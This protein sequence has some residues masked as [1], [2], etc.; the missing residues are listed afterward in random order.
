MSVGQFGFNNGGGSI[1]AN[2][3]TGDLGGDNYRAR[4]RKRPVQNIVKNT[5]VNGYPYLLPNGNP[6][7]VGE[8]VDATGITEEVSLAPL[9]DGSQAQVSVQGAQGLLQVD[10]DGY[11]YYDSKQNYAVLEKTE[12][13]Y[14]NRFKVYD[15]PR[16]I[17]D[18]YIAG[19]IKD[20][21]YNLQGQFFPFD[22]VI[23]ETKTGE[24]KS[25]FKEKDG[26]L[27]NKYEK[28][29]RTYHFGAH[30][31]T[32]FIHENGGYTDAQ[33]TKPVTYEFSGDDDVWV[34][35]DGVL[36]GD[37]GGIHDA[38]SLEINFA[39]GEVVVFSKGANGNREEEIET[40]LKECYEAA[41]KE[42]E[43]SVNEKG[44]T[45]ADDSYHT[46][47]FFYLERGTGASNMQLKY[48]LLEIPGSS[49]IKQDQIGQAV[50]GAEFELRSNKDGKDILL[51]E[52]TTDQNGT[53][54]LMDARP[55]HN[56]KNLSLKQL[57]EEGF[58]NLTLKETKIPDGYRGQAEVQLEL[59]LNNE[60][61]G[62]ILVNQDPWKTGI[63][64]SPKVRTEIPSEAY[65]YTAG[66]EH[67][68]KVTLEQ[69]KSG[70]VFAVLQK[71]VDKDKPY[72]DPDAWIPIYGDREH[73]WH[74]LDSTGDAL[75]AVIQAFKKQVNEG[76]QKQIFK[77]SSN[78]VMALEID[79][80]PGDIRNYYSLLLDKEKDKT[81]YAIAYY[82]SE[83]P[84]VDGVNSEN[85]WRLD[86][87]ASL[88]IDGNKDFDRIFATNILVPNIKNTLYVQKTDESGKPLIGAQFSLYE[89][90]QVSEEN[91]EIKLNEN[92]QPYDT[93]T[94]QEHGPMENTGSFPSTNHLLKEGTYYL[95]E[96]RAPDGYIRNSN[97]TKII[98]NKEGVFAN[99]G[100]ADDGIVVARGVGGILKSMY[101]FATLDH[102]DNTLNNIKANMEI[103]DSN[104][105]E[106]L[107][108]SDPSKWKQGGNPTEMHLEYQAS[109][110]TLKYGAI[111]TTDNPNAENRI[112]TDTGWS[113]LNIQ[114]CK[115]HH[116]ITRSKG[117]SI[118]DLEGKNITNLFSNTVTVIVENERTNP[119]SIE[120]VV[121]D[122]KQMTPL[123]D[124]EFDVHLTYGKDENSQTPVTGDYPI[125]ITTKQNDDPNPVKTDISVL[126][127]DSS[128]NAK[129]QL[130]AGK[131]EQGQNVSQKVE[132]IN[133]PMGIHY[134]I[135]ETSSERF[136]TK[137]KTD[138]QDEMA[139]QQIT[140]A[141]AKTKGEAQANQFS[142]NEIT[143]TNVYSYL[144]FI[145]VN[146]A[147]Q[148]LQGVQFGLYELNCQEQS[149]N[150]QQL[151]NVDPSS[152]ELKDE[153]CWTKVNTFTSGEDGKVLLS[154]LI[155]GKQYRLV[156]LK[157]ANGYLLP[158]GQW[159]IKQNDQGQF[160]F[161]ESIGNPPAASNQGGQYYV[162][163]YQPNELPL[164]GGRGNTFFM[165]C[166]TALMSLG[167]VM[168][169]I[170]HKKRNVK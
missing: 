87:D 46:L 165:I 96:D 70:T 34:F 23:Y 79:D 150:H 161:G 106:D 131:N 12:N 22:P 84:T 155:E 128:G 167:L 33:K 25:I 8:G 130:Q 168:W 50:P 134:S 35:I 86:S 53:F 44:T 49:I 93:I 147:N 19:N 103:N 45:F 163:N 104:N 18:P 57:Y 82:Y 67:G 69:Q 76:Y 40:T 58:R 81:E 166:G 64:A 120:K 110:E 88:Q 109:D 111:K 63:Y 142:N 90:D 11:F 62:V 92:A 158:Q 122:P 89:S 24:T 80:L 139:S 107:D 10:Q 30:M 74:R 91:G 42:V 41:G 153:S 95:F 160:S 148:P 66:S 36:V 126:K 132:I 52:G 154:G 7:L 55:D 129:I 17:Y 146:K 121:Q 83:S 99:A 47:D 6:N 113:R 125:K 3:W 1:V 118:V 124:Y 157:A 127:F 14:G 60:T 112:K 48:N 2:K 108:L 59:V 162:Y 20:P 32:R 15:Q 101:Q 65:I 141:I 170:T 39:T 27:E 13:G 136:T 85:T 151:L 169:L 105:F 156:E 61:K 75:E 137:V 43:W 135:T 54:V 37:V 164:T 159:T 123:K 117:A 144:E 100:Q 16:N 149:H 133:L 38:I 5:L 73:G 4:N 9:F 116:E 71:R 97:P 138:T 21:K 68:E 98:V 78:G 102:I 31:S 114:Q 51:A 56:N 28:D 145:K 77:L 29:P 143:F 94:I 119:L 152:G 115:E 26:Q 140:G 72:T